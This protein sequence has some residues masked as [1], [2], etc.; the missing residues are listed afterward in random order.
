MDKVREA[1]GKTGRWSSHQV[2]HWLWSVLSYRDR[3]T[4]SACIQDVLYADDVTLIA[5]TREE[6]QH[7]L[8]VLD[9][10][11]TRWGLMCISAS[12]TKILTTGEQQTHIGAVHHGAKSSLG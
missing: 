12:K 9:E 6:L 10:A 5:E 3:T 11:C 4:V 8:D 1:P 2:F 7:M